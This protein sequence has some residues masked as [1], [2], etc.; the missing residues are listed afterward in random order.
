MEFS[1]TIKERQV[2]KHQ[3]DL[4]LQAEDTITIKDFDS[5]LYIAYKDTPLISIQEDWTS[6]DIISELS[7]LRTNYVSSKMKNYTP[8][9]IESLFKMK[10][11]C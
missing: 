5:N 9:F 11:T 7:K 8:G 3:D 4:M 6:K 2:T 10:P 1:R